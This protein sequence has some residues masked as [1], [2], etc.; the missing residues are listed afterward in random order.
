MTVK[1]GAYRVNNFCGAG[2]VIG[3]CTNF[4]LGNSAYR[5]RI[6]WFG[7]LAGEPLQYPNGMASINANVQAYMDRDIYLAAVVYG[8]PNYF[9]FDYYPSDPLLGIGGTFTNWNGL[10][11]ALRMYRAARAR[12][13][14]RA[15]SRC[16]C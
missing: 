15:S 8:V 13:R 2:T 3:D 12:T 5:D 16:A 14:A 6:P 9:V 11:D 10:N 1:I 7:A 4:S